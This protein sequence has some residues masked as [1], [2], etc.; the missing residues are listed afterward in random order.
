MTVHWQYAGR[1]D[2]P[3]C[4]FCAMTLAVGFLTH[5]KMITIKKFEVLGQIGLNKQG[6]SSKTASQ[7]SHCLP[8]MLLLDAVLLCKINLF[9]LRT[10][11]IIILHISVV[12][13]C[14]F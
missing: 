11:T 9:S 1:Q 6:N 3:F 8:F 5:F 14:L 2:I 10:I 12:M 7:D 13:E 4:R